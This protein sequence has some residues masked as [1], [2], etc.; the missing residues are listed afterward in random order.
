[1]RLWSCGFFSV[2]GQLLVAGGALCL[3]GVMWGE[4]AVDVWWPVLVVWAGICVAA[5]AFFPKGRDQREQAPPHEPSDA[6]R[7][8][9]T[10]GAC[11]AIITRD[12]GEEQ[13][14]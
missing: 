3:V 11:A 13:A 8:D 2:W 7:Y 9:G 10:Y 12:G 14:Q 4:A 6:R 5:K 1:L